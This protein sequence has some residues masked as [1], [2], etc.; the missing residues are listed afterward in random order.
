MLELGAIADQFRR[1]LKRRTAAER[2]RLLRPTA[3]QA[4]S[5]LTAVLLTAA[6]LWMVLVPWPAPPWP[7]P[8]SPVVRMAMS[9][10]DPV[11]TASTQAPAP[12][13]VE[14]PVDAV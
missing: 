10:G 8:P 7:A 1:P 9:G 13:A 4:A 2:L 14:P 6:M 12:P 3:L 11:V 5:G